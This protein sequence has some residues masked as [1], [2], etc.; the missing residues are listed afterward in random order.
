MIE[1]KIPTNLALSLAN[2]K[3]GAG[4]LRV[5]WWRHCDPLIVLLRGSGTA[6][7]AR[8]MCLQVHTRFLKMR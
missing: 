5:V 2:R 8:Q 3:S 4:C 6:S 1:G 7:H